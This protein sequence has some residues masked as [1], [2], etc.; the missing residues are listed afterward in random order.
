VKRLLT[1][2]GAPTAADGIEA[3]AMLVERSAG[4][5]EIMAGGKVRGSNV[6]AIVEG[7]GV[8]EVHARVGRDESQIR[9]I[10]EALASP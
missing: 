4:R 7:A 2:G 5:I 6:R 10:V 1:S 8:K 3:L 9:G